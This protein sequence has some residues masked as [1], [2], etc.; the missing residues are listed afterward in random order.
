MAPLELETRLLEILR[1]SAAGLSEFELLKRLQA[2]APDAFPAALFKDN[3]AMYQAHF[4]LF[5]ALYRLR[6]TLLARREALLEIDVL[7]IRLHAYAKQAAGL[8]AH[9]PLRAYYLDWANL[10][11]TGAADVERLLGS[12]WTRYIANQ[13]RADA[14]R[15]LGLSDPVGLAEITRHYRRLAMNHHPD[16]GGDVARF[17]A[18]QAA[19]AALRRS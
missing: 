4:L 11:Q 19:M 14:L 18:I 15:V 17:Q 2:A 3:L 13:Q 16:R 5:H 9:D 8:E 12:F 6:D 10:E 7:A 1:A